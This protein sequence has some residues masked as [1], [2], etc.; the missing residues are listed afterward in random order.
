[1]CPH[2]PGFFATL[3]LTLRPRESTRKRCA[4]RRCV[5]RATSESTCAPA[6]GRR[7]EGHNQHPCTGSPILYLYALALVDTHLSQH[8]TI[9]V[10]STTRDTQNTTH[11]TTTHHCRPNHSLRATTRTPD[12]APSPSSQNPRLTCSNQCAHSFSYPSCTRTSLL[13]V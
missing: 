11:D 4:A 1:M 2:W 8:T 13:V 9:R 3:H 10:H 12:D 5:A 6:A 7:R